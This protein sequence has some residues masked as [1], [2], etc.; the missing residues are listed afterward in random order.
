MTVVGLI[1]LD[2]AVLLTAS[3]LSMRFEALPSLFVVL[4]CFRV[5]GLVL[6]LELIY[7]QSE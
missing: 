2:T 3:S 1:S 5:L 6:K 7:L 4:G